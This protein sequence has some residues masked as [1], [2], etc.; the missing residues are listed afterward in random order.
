MLVETEAREFGDAKLFSQDALR[1]VS[2]KNPIFQAR[3][4]AADAFEERSL[5]RLEKLLWPRKQRFPR[6]QQLQFVAKFIVG[7]RAGEFRD[8]KFTGRKIDKGQANGRTRGMFCNR[9]KKA[10]FAR[11]QK[12]DVRRRA[13][14]DHPH[15]FAAHELFTRSRLLHLIANRDFAAAADQARDVALPGVEWNA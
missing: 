7:T 14:G 1:V 10:I 3:F 5:R 9:S 13:R 11:V 2:L 8:L 12:C 4:H 15:Y 6:A